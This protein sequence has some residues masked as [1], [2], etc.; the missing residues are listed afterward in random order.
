[1]AALRLLKKGVRRRRAV[2]FSACSFSHAVFNQHWERSRCS[3]GLRS[4]RVNVKGAASARGFSERLLYFA[5][6]FYAIF[7]TRKQ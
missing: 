1:M 2:L 4:G 6:L 7:A 3:A 5:A